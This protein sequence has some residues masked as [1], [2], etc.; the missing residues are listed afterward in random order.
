[1]GY[2]L[3]LFAVLVYAVWRGWRTGLLHQLAGVLGI[4][5]GVVMTRMF[6]CPVSLWILENY[7]RLGEGFAGDYKVR[8][9]ASAL[10]F[11]GVYMLFSLLAGVLRSA[12]SLLHVGALNAM[13]GAAFSLLK[14][15]VIMSVIYN[16]LLSVAPDSELGRICDDG[17]GN[18]VEIVMSAAPALIGIDGPDEL[19]HKRKLEEAKAISQL[20]GQE[21]TFGPRQPL[22]ESGQSCE[23]I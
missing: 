20:H 13:A 6:C 10:I 19:E 1:M 14:W 16:V 12:L 7:P 5:F 9:L 4:G 3:V 15:V 11:G 18:L 21:A 17:D 23:H 22:I 8:M 2:M